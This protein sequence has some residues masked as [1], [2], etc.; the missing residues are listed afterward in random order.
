MYVCPICRSTN[1]TDY[2]L[3]GVGSQGAGGVIAYD[4]LRCRTHGVEIAD[5][6]GIDYGNQ[7]A[8][9]SLDLC[10]GPT[11]DL[12]GRY[13]VMMDQVDRVRSTPG[14][15]HD[16]GCA[17]GHLMDEAARRDWRVRGNDLVL[18]PTPYTHER[19]QGTLPSLG[20]PDE[21]A[22]VVTQF[23][24]LPHLTDPI[25]ELE[26][27]YRLLRPGGWLVSQMPARGV[28]RRAAHAL[29]HISGGRYRTALASVHG[30][31]GHPYAYDRMSVVALLESVGFTDCRTWDYCVPAR[32]S[33]IRYQQAPLRTRL[34]ATVALYALHALSRVPGLA[35]HMIV[36][37][38]RP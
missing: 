6:P 11:V 31:G 37:G 8:V 29:Y 4:V 23:C 17:H 13:R 30:P 34:L 12:E 28:Y 14:D 16:V 35:N 24:V 7:A 21:S 33:L 2:A 9:A 36:V 18:P 10:Y 27:T 22:D 38:Q 20:L 5:A 25:H 3:V 26:A 19:H 32:W 1:R 15:L